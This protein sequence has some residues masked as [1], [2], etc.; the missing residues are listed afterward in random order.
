MFPQFR[1]SK[2]AF[3]FAH[4]SFPN[5][6]VDAEQDDSYPKVTTKFKNTLKLPTEGFLQKTHF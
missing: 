3:S 6:I 2:Y 5:L 1:Y 4:V